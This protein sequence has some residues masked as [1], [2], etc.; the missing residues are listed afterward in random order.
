MTEESASLTVRQAEAEDMTAIAEMA[1]EFHAYL[2]AL[3]GS[4]P[5]FDG[6]RVD[7]TLRKC[8]FGGRPLFSALI[9]EKGG[10]PVGYAIYSIGF[11]AD[12]WQGMVLVS[13]LY[14]RQ[15]WRARGIGREL[16][17]QLAAAGKR[18]GCGMV[19]WTVWDK[20]EPAKRFYD[21]LGGVALDDEQLMSL[22]I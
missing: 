1:G 11:W 21:R 5:S 12:A 13:D 17:R 7:S 10:Q 16:M 3:D 9:A 15:A 18:E 6:A 14:V 8:G 2:A 22:P 4:D 20:N 19:M